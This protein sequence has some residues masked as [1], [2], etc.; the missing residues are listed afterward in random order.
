MIHLVI[1]GRPPAKNDHKRM[2]VRGNRAMA[3]FRWLWRLYQQQAGEG[4][5]G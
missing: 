5:R 4:A 2:A 3:Y 1:P